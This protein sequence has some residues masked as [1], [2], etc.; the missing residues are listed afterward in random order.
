[1]MKSPKSPDFFW[2]P[3][4]SSALEHPSSTATARNDKMRVIRDEGQQSPHRWRPMVAPESP[5]RVAGPPFGGASGSGPLF[6]VSYDS[7]LNRSTSARA[8]SNVPAPYLLSI[9]AITVELNPS[10]YESRSLSAKQS[11]CSTLTPYRDR[12]RSSKNCPHAPRVPQKSRGRPAWIS[13]IASVRPRSNA[14]GLDSLMG[15]QSTI[16]VLGKHSY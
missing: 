6:F 3:C 1:M 10:R 11:V 2:Y 7:F 16:F 8:L 15:M 12:N 13:R 9:W 5:E 14:T 4:K